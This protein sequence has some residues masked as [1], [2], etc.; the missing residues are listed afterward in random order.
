MDALIWVI[1]ELQ[2]YIVENPDFKIGKMMLDS[3]ALSMNE[4]DIKEID[5]DIIRAW[6]NY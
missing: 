1:D 5:N 6:K 2:E 3:W 4:I